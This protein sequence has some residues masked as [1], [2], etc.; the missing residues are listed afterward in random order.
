MIC[1]VTFLPFKQIV[2]H[3]Q[4]FAKNFKC[5]FRVGEFN[6]RLEK[7]QESQSAL[8]LTSQVP[9]LLMQPLEKK[10]MFPGVATLAVA[11]GLFLKQSVRAEA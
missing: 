9:V 5:S 1:V 6:A 7:S 3:P 4:K 10:E 8:R 11:V 2:I